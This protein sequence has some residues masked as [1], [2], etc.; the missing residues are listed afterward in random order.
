[1]APPI[2]QVEAG[3]Y[4]IPLPV[5]LSDSTHGSIAAFELVTVRVRDADG[6]EGVGYTYTVG[7]GGRA[8]HA[9]IAHDL[10]PLLTGRDPERIEA[11]WQ[12]MWWHVHYGGRGGAQVLAISAIDVALWDLR[13]RRQGAP[14]WRVL[15]GFDPRVPCYAGGID[16][17][18]PVDA[19][20]RQTDENVARGFRAIK[21]KVGRPT[22]REDVERVRAMRAHLGADFPLMVDANMRWSVDDA[23]RAARALR[24]LDVVWL[25]EPT[26]PDDV[27]GHVRI[28][29]EGGLPIAAGENLHT[30]HEFRQLIAA[31]GVTFPEPDVT[32]C[33]GVTA[34]M[35]VCHLAEAFNLPVTSHGAHDVTVH[36]L[37]AVP[38]RSYLEAHGFGLDRF[39]ETPLRIE[40]GVAVAPERP[41]HGIAFDWKGLGA[42]STTLL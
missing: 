4:R 38:N 1:M 37:A 6:A 35:K 20:L 13:A 11:L 33:G 31:G 23:I 27:P 15:G 22:L 18:F 41:G 25:E 9:L 40:A 28:V 26:I 30:L 3:C 8:A 12:A 24:E 19:L 34:F 36:L 7:T 2:R 14:L 29:R 10:T 39:I 42:L 32:N 21:M 5:T 16:L 17:D